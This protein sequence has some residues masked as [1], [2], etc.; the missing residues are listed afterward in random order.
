M[1]YYLNTRG[2]TLDY[3]FLGHSPAESW[4]REYDPFT[5]FESPTLIVRGDGY[6]VDFYLSGIPSVRRAEPRG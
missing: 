6:Q 1:K 2:R 4:W 3:R 5:K